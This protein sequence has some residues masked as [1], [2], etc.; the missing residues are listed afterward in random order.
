MML[1]PSIHQYSSS[2]SKVVFLWIHNPRN[3]ILITLKINNNPLISYLIHIQIYPILQKSCIAGS[4][5]QD[6]I[7]YEFIFR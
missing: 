4:L 1:S 7:K 6:P 5:N 3:V 2:E